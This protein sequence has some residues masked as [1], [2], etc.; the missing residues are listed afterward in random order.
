MAD[1]IVALRKL[2]GTRPVIICGASVIILDN[3]GRILLQHRVDN[4]MWGLPGGAMEIGE[5]FE[6]T[7]ICE[8]Y[9][10]V[11]LICKN[12]KFFNT[13]SGSK[14]YYKYPNG[15]EL[16][17]ATVT[18]ICKDFL[19]QIVVDKTEGKDARFFDI[20]DIPSIISPPVKDIINDFI[21]QYEDIIAM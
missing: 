1:Y 16:Y 10:E 18:Y 11:G 13:Y 2:I 7:A 4:D 6:E 17:N 5:S 9:E 21:L 20:N 15:D 12:L 3:I 19:G 8:A 14:F